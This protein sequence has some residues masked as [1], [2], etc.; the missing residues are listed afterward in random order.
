[1]QPTV[2]IAFDLNL[3]GAGDFLTLDEPVRGKLDDSTYPLA[4]EV[5]VDVSEH[6]RSVDFKRGRPREIDEFDAGQ[7]SVTLDNRTRLFDP[8]APASV[9]AF[10]AGIL[11]RKQIRVE[12]DGEPLFD[13]QVED[14][15]LEYSTSGDSIT[16]AKASD[17]FTILGQQLLS[18]GAASG[19]A[20]TGYSGSV[21]NAVLSDAAVDWPISKR[22]I[23]RGYSLIGDQVI[24]TNVKALNFLQD[25]A[26]GEPGAFFIGKD[27]RATFR[28][29]LDLQTPTSLVF[30]D[31]GSGIP[32][33]NIEVEFGTENLFT[34][35]EVKYPTDQAVKATKTESV[36]KFG[37]TTLTVDTFLSTTAQ[38]QDLATFYSER[39]GD[40]TY[41]VTGLGLNMD[42]LTTAQQ[43][44]ILELE[45]GDV[46]SIRW[47]PN[48]IGP[49]ISRVVSLDQISHDIISK[50]T[51][52]HRVFLNFSET[53]ASFVLDDTTF[54]VLDQNFLAF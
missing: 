13:G 28:E 26:N 22:N 25:V 19:F 44:S 52:E 51:A 4:G 24:G 7:L 38:A 10:A 16:I 53:L 21:I 31:D 45:L 36:D 12:V 33:T 42:T 20:F 48:G 54:G 37:L 14:W 5:L 3:S 9:S 1:M 32:F 2:F 50:P 8:T 23:D 41:L 35:V 34:Q 15:D 40:P 6:V 47:T 27:G 29:R 11:P 49:A 39:F 46:V 43:E 17:G 30:T 18:S